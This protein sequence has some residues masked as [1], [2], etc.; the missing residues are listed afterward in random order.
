MNFI[1]QNKTDAPLVNTFKLIWSHPAGKVL[2]GVGA[3]FGA[4]Y[5][6]GMAFRALA[7]ATRGL[8]EFTSALKS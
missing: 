3:A 5:L 1:D 6:G 8:K 2:F 4:L 7:Y